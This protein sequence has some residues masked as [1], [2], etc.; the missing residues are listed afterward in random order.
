M[1]LVPLWIASTLF[2]THG[3]ADVQVIHW[4]AAVFGIRSCWTGD[5]NG[6]GRRD[7]AVSEPWRSDEPDF[8]GRVE[9]LC[10]VTGAVLHTFEGSPP[11]LLLGTALTATPDVD[12]D[13]IDDVLAAALGWSASQRGGSRVLELVLLG[14]RGT[15][16]RSVTYPDS[17]VIAAEMRAMAL[18]NVPAGTPNS[19]G[20]LVAVERS[21]K[22]A[23]ASW[24]VPFG[25]ERYEPR[26][27]R[28]L[29][30]PPYQMGPLTGHLPL[31]LADGDRCLL[32]IIESDGPRVIAVERE[33][34]REVLRLAPQ[35]G[36]MEHFGCAIA[37]LHVEGDTAGRIVVSAPGGCNEA[38][39][40]APAPV[41]GGSRRPQGEV[42]DTVVWYRADDG[43]PVA[44]MCE[45]DFAAYVR[46][47]DRPHAHDQSH[48]LG[49]TLH[50][51]PHRQRGQRVSDLL[52][53]A[54]SMYRDG[55]ALVMDPENLAP[56]AIAPAST[57]Y[58]GSDAD[59]GKAWSLA[60]EPA[61]GPE[62][63]R[64]L[65]GTKTPFGGIGSGVLICS[66][67]DG[68]ILLRVVR[69]APRLDRSA[70]GD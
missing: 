57:D 4:G 32:T 53:V 50:A 35:A 45:A 26:W 33:T 7:I 36:D 30:G 2:L 24:G 3:T 70:S 34:G 22:T 27:V 11:A 49:T 52:V 63:P 12:G 56:L 65:L 21:D 51:V 68:A 47:F 38:H 1:S 69:E 41:E 60:V 48:D 16:V 44:R 61:D 54:D 25:G 6:D 15:V 31:A 23:S 42:H 67:T 62:P 64:L 28:E 46:G 5:W 14:S 40:E 17:E 43:T 58:P 55:T 20:V 8:C 37:Y 10:S 66:S 18:P 19:V 29:G 59:W 39:A 9:V 13:G